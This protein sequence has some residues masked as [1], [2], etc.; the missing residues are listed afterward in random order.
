LTTKGE[1]I[2]EL[3]YWVGVP[4]WGRGYASEAAAEVIRFGF[5]DCGMHRIYGCHYA[6]NPASGRILEKVGMTREGTFRQHILKWGEYLDVV[7]YGLLRE[8]WL[9]QSR[10]GRT[11]ST[12]ARQNE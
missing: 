3:G 8:E 1:G 9:Q 10:A 6:R 5:E 11:V 2:A 4:F 7:Y 12:T